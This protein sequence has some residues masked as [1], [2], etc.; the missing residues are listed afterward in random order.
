MLD[1]FRLRV[2]KG[3]CDVLKSITVANGYAHDMADFQDSA[4]RTAERV[5]RGRDFFGDNDPLPMLSVLEDPRSPEAMNGPT[6]SAK[7]QNTLRLLIQGFT[8]DDKSH[9]LDPAYRLSADTIK[10]IAAAKRSDTGVLGLNRPLRAPCVMAVSIGQ[11]IHRPGGDDVSDHAYFLVG[12]TLL[13]A[14][15]LENPFAT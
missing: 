8:K 6:T 1:P 10:A 12:L 14:E 4:G 11:P 15:D 5:F 2:M 13:L 3:V 9:P 7:S